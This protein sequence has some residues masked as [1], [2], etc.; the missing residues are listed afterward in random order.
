MN[1]LI[2]EAKPKVVVID[3]SGVF[4]LEYSALKMLIQAEQ[5]RREEGVT[6]WLTELSPEVFTTVQRSPLG[7]ILGRERMLHNLEIAV[8]KYQRQSG[9]VEGN[10]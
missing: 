8:E 4:D 9:T 10:S 6:L 7:E 1:R 2:A 3:M 5:R